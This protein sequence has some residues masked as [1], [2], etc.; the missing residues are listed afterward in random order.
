VIGIRDGDRTQVEQPSFVFVFRPKARFQVKITSYAEDHDEWKMHL[1][2]YAEHIELA[3][4]Q[5]SISI[6][7][8]PYDQQVDIFV[9]PHDQQMAALCDRIRSLDGQTGQFTQ[10]VGE[11]D[12]HMESLSMRGSNRL[13]LVKMEGTN[14]TRKMKQNIEVEANQSTVTPEPLAPHPRPESSP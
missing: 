12:E 1:N 11:L 13:D 10:Q 7:L 6:L 2:R 5:M 9:L 14:T 4:E 8:L 3:F